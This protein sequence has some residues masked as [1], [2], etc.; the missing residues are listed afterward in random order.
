MNSAFECAE[1]CSANGN[2]SV[3][4]LS[5]VSPG[6]RQKT[7]RLR[8]VSGVSDSVDDR[9]A[10]GGRKHCQRDVGQILTLAH[11]HT[12]VL[13]TDPNVPFAKEMQRIH[14]L[15]ARLGEVHPL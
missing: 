11:L 7:C 4:D 14:G 2:C 10:I 13:H 9:Q 3:W 8:G 1:L 15:T 12:H 5:R 6:S